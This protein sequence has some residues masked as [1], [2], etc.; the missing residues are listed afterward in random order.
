MKALGLIETRGLIASVES[1]DA[2]L[3]AAQVSLVEKVYVG[4]GL[5]TVTVTGDVGAVKASVEAGS[6]AVRQLDSTLLISQHV[7]PR[8]HQELEQLIGP[9]KQS[10]GKKS[11]I[12]EQPN[13]TILQENS[14][15]SVVEEQEDSNGSAVREVTD[16]T[17]EAVS[18]EMD[19]E[20]ID[21]EKVD[22]AVEDYSIE[23]V[24]GILNKLKVVKLRNLARQYKEFGISENLISKTDK[25]ML[26]AEFENYYRKK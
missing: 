22:Q 19:L 18:L 4:G 25:K 14:K 1:A 5:V 15:A 20:Q 21:K 2:M 16:G 10:Y 11:L 26:L 13:R 23:I 7:I 9:P 12:K 3:K 17:E 8:P 6:A 24:V